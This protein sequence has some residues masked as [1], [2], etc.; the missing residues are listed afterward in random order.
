MD[1]GWEFIGIYRD[2]FRVLVLRVLELKGYLGF[3][4][5]LFIILLF[6]EEGKYIF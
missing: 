6:G 1:F 2:L 5:W 3:E 4:G